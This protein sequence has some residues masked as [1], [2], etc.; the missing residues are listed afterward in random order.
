[1]TRV[2]LYSKPGCHLC[3]QMK[4]VITRVATKI[5]LA[6]EEIDI[7]RD[8]ELMRLY[9]Q[10]IPVLMIEG[11]RAAKYRVTEDSLL[12]ILGARRSSVPR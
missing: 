1:M 9:G 10:D 3:E 12:R 4:D 6:L 8:D 7:S 11:K 5:P 2:T